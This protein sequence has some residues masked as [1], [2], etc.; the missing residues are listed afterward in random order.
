MCYGTTA[1]N[2]TTVISDQ[3]TAEII[4]GYVVI[5]DDTLIWD[6][7]DGCEVAPPS[8][9]VLISNDTEPKQLRYL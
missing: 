1:S 5:D 2:G 9:H 4:D 8:N 3:T 7:E 6:Y